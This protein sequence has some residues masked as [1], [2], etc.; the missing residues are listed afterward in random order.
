VQKEAYYL[1]VPCI[2]M[3][4]V[5]EWT[6]TVEAG[7]NVLCGADTERI[8]DAVRRSRQVP[9]GHP[10]LFG[11]GHAAERIVR[12]LEEG[13]PQDIPAEAEELHA[14]QRRKQ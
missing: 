4:E 8:E 10:D 1:K 11:D 5:T 2:T 3:R 12:C 14:S 9:A 7:W 6:E 13:A